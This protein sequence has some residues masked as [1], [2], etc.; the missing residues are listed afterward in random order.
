MPAIFEKYAHHGREVWVRSAL[1]ARHRQHCLCHYCRGFKPDDRVAN[2]P[3]ANV[4]YNLDVLLGLVTPVWE[5][6]KFKEA[7]QQND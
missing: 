6:P 4:L 2:C 3:I 5:C 7:E 1:K